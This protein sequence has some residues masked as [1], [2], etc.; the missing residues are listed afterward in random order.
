MVKN[1]DVLLLARL[2]GV[3]ARKCGCDV[4]VDIRPLAEELG[5]DMDAVMKEVIGICATRDYNVGGAHVF[6]TMENVV[7][8]YQAS[9]T[10][11]LD[12]DHVEGLAHILAV[13][14]GVCQDY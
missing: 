10:L 7:P 3:V 6:C 13:H 4:R 9:G 11:I 14:R 12:K 8:E 2:Q 5:L 1:Y